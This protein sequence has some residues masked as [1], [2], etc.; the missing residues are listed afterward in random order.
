MGIKISTIKKI[1]EEFNNFFGTIAENIYK[2]TPKSNKHFANYIKN[3]NLNSFFLDAVTEDEIESIIGNLN[4]RKTIGPN[5]IPTRILKEFENM[6]KTP[7]TV[8][9]NISFQTGIFPEQCKIA[10]ITSVFKK[11]DTLD[12][13]N[14]R[15]VSLL[16]N[17]SKIL[18]KAMYT[19]LYKFLDK[20]KCLY[21]KQV[22]FRN[23]HS[24]NH[25]LVSITEE[26]K[27]SLD[28]GE[29]AWGFFLYFRKTFDTV[30]HNILIAKL[31]HYGIRG[32]TL[33]WFQSY[34][35]NCKQQ[36]SINNTLSN[37]TMISCG[38]PQGSVLGPLLFLMYIN[39]LNEA[40]SHSLIHHFAYDTNVLF[41]SKSLKKINK[42]YNHDLAEI[43]I[44]QKLSSSDLQ[45]K[46][47]F[48]KIF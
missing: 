42:Y 5:S 38:V 44:K 17:I 47:N 37:E 34:L 35:T 39:D 2:K 45:S 27:Q 25:A 26:I 3:Q 32:I 13:S 33:D 1:S 46:K 31:N 19:R 18:E 22:G 40:I 16:S 24:T 4:S 21:E 41:S 9:I 8:I 6:L 23:F 20:F 29:F 14:Y 15:P 48:K 11:G 10:H 12:S 28:K 36:I 7:L 43:E 30:N